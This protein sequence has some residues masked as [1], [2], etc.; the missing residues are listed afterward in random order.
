MTDK[1]APA[2]TREE[3]GMRGHCLYFHGITVAR[4]H[5]GDV[6]LMDGQNPSPAARHALAALC[7]SGQPFGFTRE[8]VIR[9]S[10]LIEALEHAD[11]A[12]ELLVELIVLDPNPWR[13][14]VV[15]IAALLPPAP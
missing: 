6:G 4:F 14:L 12:Q 2:L 8:D 11:T 9:L 3:W 13:Q 1:I 10:A 7:L 5:E 15:R